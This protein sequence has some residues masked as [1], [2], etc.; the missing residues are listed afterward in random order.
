MTDTTDQSSVMVTPLCALLEK[1]R[2]PS[3]TDEQRNAMVRAS[4]DEQND[5][6]RRHQELCDQRDARIDNLEA[7]IDARVDARLRELGLLDTSVAGST[8][9]G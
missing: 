8:D 6:R 2:D 9:V 3:L 1:L 5:A 4:I 7:L